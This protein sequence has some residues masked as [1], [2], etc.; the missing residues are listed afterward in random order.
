MRK[1]GVEVREEDVE[2]RDASEGCTQGGGGSWPFWGG[3]VD[4]GLETDH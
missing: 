1:E 3:G 4:D 2:R